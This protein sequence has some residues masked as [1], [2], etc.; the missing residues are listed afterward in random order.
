MSIKRS[1][2]LPWVNCQ[3]H[4][5]IAW[6]SVLEFHTK[7]LSKPHFLSPLKRHLYERGEKPQSL[8]LICVVLIYG[9]D[10]VISCSACELLS[11]YDEL[12]EVPMTCY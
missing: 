7:Y 5:W 4:C 3:F 6:N 1:I 2:L 9:A 8:Y 11:V 10:I 12:N